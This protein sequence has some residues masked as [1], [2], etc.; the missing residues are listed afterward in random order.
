M[1]KIGVTGEKGFIGS[2][3]V[4]TLKLYK[5][6]YEL[7]PFEKNFFKN[8]KK[9]I[10]FIKKCNV[11][12]HLAALNRHKSDKVIVNTNILLVNKLIDALIISKSNVQVIFS[13]SSQEACQNSYGNSKKN[14]REKFVEW[15]KNSNNSFVGMLIPNVFGPFGLPNY[16][17]FISTFCYKLTHGEIPKINIDK[18]INLIYVLD[19]VAKIIHA[20]DNGYNNSKWIIEPNLNASVSEIF[21]KLIFFKETYFVNGEIPNLNSEFDT[22]LFNTFRS[23]I[24]LNSFFPKKLFNNIDNRGSFVE[25]IKEK[26]GGQFS[27]STTKPGIVRGN[28]FHTRKIERFA[29]IKGKALIQMRKIGT[30]EIYE[31][32]LNGDEPSFVDMPIWCTHNIKNIGKDIL[33]TNFWISEYYDVNDSDTFTEPV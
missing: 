11:I 21:K 29:V 10:E 8:K 23:Y 16:N 30:D 20:I 27:F 3:L 15:A 28:H 9:L 1:L 24:N 19:L 33:F 13:S 25:I 14:G 6:K 32:I 4:N 2:H 7:V 17:S 18:N 22:N 26:N 12:V 5:T 31:F